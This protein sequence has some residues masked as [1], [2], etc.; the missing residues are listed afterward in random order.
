M[1]ID[2]NADSNDISV[3][4]D[5]RKH[6]TVCCGRCGIEWRLFAPSPDVAEIEITWFI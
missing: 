4:H 3:R 2:C 5:G 1:Y 6:C